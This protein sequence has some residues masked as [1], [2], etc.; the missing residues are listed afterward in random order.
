MRNGKPGARPA[1]FHVSE[2]AGSVAEQG[3][4]SSHSDRIMLLR[5]SDSYQLISMRKLHH[6]R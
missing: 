3:P 5:I 1:G 6:L 4:L 2:R